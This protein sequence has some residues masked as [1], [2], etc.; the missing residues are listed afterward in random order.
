MS[1]VT[2]VLRAL[3]VVCILIL[4][5]PARAAEVTL[6]IDPRQQAKRIDP[7]AVGWGASGSRG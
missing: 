6:T 2:P 3:C 4:A 5:W 7:G 1:L